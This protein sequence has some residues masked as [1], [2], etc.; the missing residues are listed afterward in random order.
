LLAHLI[1]FYATSFTV[2]VAVFA[3]KEKP[4]KTRLENAI[5][6]LSLGGQKTAKNC[7]TPRLL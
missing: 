1:N 7:H 6:F 4:V 2:P 3:A 5:L